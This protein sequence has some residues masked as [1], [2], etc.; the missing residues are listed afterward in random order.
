MSKA[1][2]LAGFE[3]AA[4]AMAAPL[5]REPD[6]RNF[7]TRE[8]EEKRIQEMK[9]RDRR[10]RVE[11]GTASRP[12]RV[13]DGRFVGRQHPA[14]PAR[15]CW[16]SGWSNATRRRKILQYHTGSIEGHALTR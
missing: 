4:E 5:G 16:M 11:L 13:N 2:M 7:A 3:V 10:A 8:R 14:A 15:C 12:G 1:L 9:A 6:A